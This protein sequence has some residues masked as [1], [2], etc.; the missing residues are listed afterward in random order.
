MIVFPWNCVLMLSKKMINVDIQAQNT[1]DFTDILESCTKNIDA[2]CTS[3]WICCKWSITT[4][5][6]ELTSSEHIFGIVCYPSCT[7]SNL[8]LQ[9]YSSHLLDNFP[10]CIHLCNVTPWSLN[11]RS[12]KEPSHVV[13]DNN[14]EERTSHMYD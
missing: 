7:R 11:R 2:T 3:V 5:F 10:Q 12:S 13:P 8:L 6:C 4:W 14:W 9:N 1:N